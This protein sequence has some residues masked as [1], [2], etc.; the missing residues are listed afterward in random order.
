MSYSVFLS[1]ASVCNNRRLSDSIEIKCVEIVV[2][3]PDALTWIQ[4]TNYST[5]DNNCLCT[6]NSH[7]RCSSSNSASPKTPGVV[8][9][10]TE[11]ESLTKEVSLLLLLLMMMM[12]GV[13][14]IINNYCLYN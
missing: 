2:A 13:I 6:F 8:V 7:G 4:P 3:R 12:V 1:Q 10:P 11:A 14:F 9:N 5:D